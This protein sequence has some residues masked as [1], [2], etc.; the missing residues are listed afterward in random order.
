MENTNLDDFICAGDI[1]SDTSCQGDQGGPFVCFDESSYSHR[2]TLQSGLFSQ[3]KTDRY[4]T[5]DE[6][7]KLLGD[8]NERLQFPNSLI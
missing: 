1:D 6:K 4:E 2:L 5:L 7:K 8:C 3:Y